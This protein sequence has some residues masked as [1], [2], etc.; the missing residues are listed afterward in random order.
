MKYLRLFEEFNEDDCK[1]CDGT[2]EEYVSCCGDDIKGTEYE[3][4]GICPTCKEHL[5]GPEPCVEC[6]GTGKAKK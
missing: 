1:A 3:D 4:M 2:G 6:G 5:G